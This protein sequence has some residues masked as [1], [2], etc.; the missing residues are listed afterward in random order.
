MYDPFAYLPAGYRYA[1]H[2][3]TVNTL[4]QCWLSEKD[5]RMIAIQQSDANLA[6]AE[7]L[8]PTWFVAI[9][10]MEEAKWTVVGVSV[11]K[12]T[13]AECKAARSAIR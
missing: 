11:P 13:A 3:S 10:F 9:G 7:Q 2:T 5:I 8:N 12:P 1:D 4:V 6:L